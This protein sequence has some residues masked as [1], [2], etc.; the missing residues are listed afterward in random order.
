[1]LTGIVQYLVIGTVIAWAL[2]TPGGE[3]EDTPSLAPEY[4]PMTVV[5]WPLVILLTMVVSLISKDEDEE[6]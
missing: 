6:A 3:L 4:V 2:A 1:M 5:L